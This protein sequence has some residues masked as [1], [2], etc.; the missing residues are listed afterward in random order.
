MKIDIKPMSVNGAWKGQR[1]K[2]P[3]YVKYQRDVLFMLPTTT[4]PLAPLKIDLTYG[5][6]SKSADIDN[7]TKQIL[8]ILQ[9]KYK[10]NDKDIYVLNL[11]K[12]IVP[13]GKEY[14]EFFISHIEY[15]D[16]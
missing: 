12:R 5:F 9:K 13:K 7:P 14:F 3:E 10:F 11:K 8:D 2:T 6:S 15:Y 1:F 4:I 16:M